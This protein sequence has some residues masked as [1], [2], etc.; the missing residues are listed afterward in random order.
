MGDLAPTPI[1][2]WRLGEVKLPTTSVLL[3]EMEA[4]IKGRI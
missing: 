3:A 1:I 2:G 4:D